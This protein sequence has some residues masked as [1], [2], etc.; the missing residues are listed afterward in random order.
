MLNAQPGE[1]ATDPH[2]QKLWDRPT[3]STISDGKKDP[4]NLPR[5]VRNSP[6]VSPFPCP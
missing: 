3:H 6:A 4:R 5:A 1:F 2:A